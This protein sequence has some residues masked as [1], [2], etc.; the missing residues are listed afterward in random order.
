MLYK[1]QF[2]SCL[3]YAMMQIETAYDYLIGIIK[4]N[5][6]EINLESVKNFRRASYVY[7]DE[8]YGLASD[9]VE[10]VRTRGNAVYVYC[11]CCSDVDDADNWIR[12]R[13]TDDM[14]FYNL[15]ELGEAIDKWASTND[16]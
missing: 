15:C 6:G 11:S 3:D 13:T 14:I 10:R 2:F 16:K 1:D 5:G 12:V 4:D 7:F 9:W 8:T